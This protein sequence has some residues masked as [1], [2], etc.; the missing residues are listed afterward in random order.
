MRRAQKKPAKQSV[1]IKRLPRTA[2]QLVADK[3]EAIGLPAAQLARGSFAIV[4]VKLDRGEKATTA[5][6][7]VNRGG[8]PVA[9][10]KAAKL[11]S[12]SQVAAVDH[13]EQLWSM[14]GGK[15]L[16]ADMSKI[17]GSGGCSDWAEQEALDNLRW[18]KGY[19]PAKWWLVFE[20]VCRFDEGAGFAGSS[21]TEVRSD[22]VTAARITV[23]FVADII[24]MKE[25]LTS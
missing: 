18:I 19:L 20:N 23:Q 21:L 8:T 17:S 10:W 22:Q 5:T 3:A 12:E 4:D 25:R 15:S 24:A 7:L 16:V 1:K 9:R 2:A 6:T 13:C 11:L 14:L